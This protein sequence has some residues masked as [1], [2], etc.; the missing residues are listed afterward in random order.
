MDGLTSFERERI[1]RIDDFAESDKPSIFDAFDV[2]ALPSTAESFGIAYLEAW[3]CRKP[4][5][6]ASIGPTRCVIDDGVDGLLVDPDDSQ[7][8]AKSI[9]ELLSDASQRRSMGEKGYA[10]TVS[11]FTWEQVTDK[12]EGLYLDLTSAAGEYP[13]VLAKAER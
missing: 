9:I 1:V 10:K 4:V 2:F 7:D 12:M 8:I 5:I 3:L 13:R 11:Y 6:G